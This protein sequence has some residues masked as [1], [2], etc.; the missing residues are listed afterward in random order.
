[1]NRRKLQVNSYVYDNA[2]FTVLREGAVRI[3]YAE[4]GAFVDVE[5]FFAR[6]DAVCDAEFCSKNGVLTAK[7]PKLTLKYSGGGF[8][9]GDRRP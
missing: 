4:G 2:R 8:S 9:A 6:R 1:M 5:T 3:E 7:T